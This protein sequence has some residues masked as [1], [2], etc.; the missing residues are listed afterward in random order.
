VWPFYIGF[1]AV[2]FILWWMA[3]WLGRKFDEL[4]K[5][6]DQIEDQIRKEKIEKPGR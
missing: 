2:I 4:E 1:A 3:S 5:R 6:F